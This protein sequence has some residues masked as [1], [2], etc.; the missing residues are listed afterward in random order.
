MTDIKWTDIVMAVFTI[1]IAGAAIL[2][3]REM[4]GGGTQTDKLVDYA[5]TQAQA[6]SDIAQASDD[7]TDS[8]KW[9]EEHMQ[10]AANAMQDSVDTA[11]RNTQTT[12]KNAETVFR[13]EQRAWVGVLAVTDI[14]GFTETEVWKVKVVFFNSGR[15]PARK[16]QTSGMY[17]TSPVPLSG[18]PLEN[19]KQLTFRPRAVDGSPRELSRSHRNRLSGG[20]FHS[21]PKTRPASAAFSIQSHQKQATLF[22]LLR[23]SEI[24]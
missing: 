2:Q 8:S 10:D 11:D 1:V 18:P 16:V 21:T 3:W 22:V 6:A 24:R 4:V 9:M 23:D 15:T 17:V 7:F 13:A 5:K 19:I 20:R 12:I 14:T